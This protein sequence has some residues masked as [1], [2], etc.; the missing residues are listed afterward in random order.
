MVC[1]KSWLMAPEDTK[2]ECGL[3][4]ATYAANGETDRKNAANDFLNVVGGLPYLPKD[5]LALEISEK[6]NN[7]YA[8]HTG[9]NNFHNE[10]SH[11]RA[12]NAYISQ[13]G[14][15][16]DPVRRSYVKTLIMAKIGNGYGVSAMAISYYDDLLAKFGESEIK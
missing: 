14:T 10:P 16:P 12:L 3:K 15:I 2:Y 1:M 8:A 4:Y 9:F 5:T 11:A 13:A 7:L 6:V